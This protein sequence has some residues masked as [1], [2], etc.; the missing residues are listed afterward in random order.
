MVANHAQ[1]SQ[2]EIHEGGRTAQDVGRQSG[3]AAG[4]ERRPSGQQEQET[5]GQAAAVGRDGGERD[6]KQPDVGGLR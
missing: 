1:P 3:L 2:K 5:V 6:G 4:L